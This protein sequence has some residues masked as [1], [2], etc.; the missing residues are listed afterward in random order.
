M[1]K[2]FAK[3][4]VTKQGPVTSLGFCDDWLTK[5]HALGLAMYR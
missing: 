3:F 2:N 4:F 1:L 5:V